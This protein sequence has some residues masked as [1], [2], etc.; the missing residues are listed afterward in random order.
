M[1][2]PRYVRATGGVSVEIAG[3]HVM[4]G[5]DMNEYFGFRDVAAFLWE[6][7]EHPRSLDELCAAVVA[8]YDV[9][10]ATCRRD[11]EAFLAELVEQRLAEVQ[12]EPRLFDGHMTSS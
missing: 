9:A 4:L 6:Q 2:G 1:T 7:L 5:P 12:D 8:E 10:E 3:E 11:T